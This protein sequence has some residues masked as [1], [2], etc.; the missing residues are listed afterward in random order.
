MEVIQAKSAGFCFGVYRAVR[1]AY[2]LAGREPR[3]R[4]LGAVFITAMWWRN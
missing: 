2:E 3:S 4:M 1:M